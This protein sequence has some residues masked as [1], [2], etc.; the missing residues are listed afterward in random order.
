MIAVANALFLENDLLTSTSNLDAPCFVPPASHISI[1]SSLLVHPT[2]TTRSKD[3]RD[4]SDTLPKALAYLQNILTIVGPR[5]AKLGEAFAFK[6]QSNRRANARDRRHARE[7]STDSDE[8][9]NE[10]LE[11]SL[12]TTDSIWAKA[13]DFWHVVGWIFNCSVACKER[14]EYWKI[15][16][17]YMIDVIETDWQERERR[18]LEA[19]E[20]LQNS[21]V[22]AEIV[23]EARVDSILCQYI[24]DNRITSPYKRLIRSIFADGNGKFLTEFPEVFAKETMRIQKDTSGR[25]RQKLGQVDLENGDFGGYGSS[26]DEVLEDIQ[27]GLTPPGSSPEARDVYDTGEDASVALGGQESVTLRLRLMALVCY[28][29]FRTQNPLLTKFSYQTLRMSC[30]LMPEQFLER[31][32]SMN[33]RITWASC[34]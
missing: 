12:A 33:S 4:R 30:P 31:R 10:D 19:Y 20:Q 32:S 2:Y 16:L 29:I 17:S 25:K 22:R 3:P 5:N 6:A 14:W 21:D 34:P 26:D 13:Q 7:A 11:S 15:W 9:L 28:S 1:I 27:Q 23:T 18:D 24:S 8:G